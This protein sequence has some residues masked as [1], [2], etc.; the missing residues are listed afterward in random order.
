MRI[1]NTNNLG[2]FT[3]LFFAFPYLSSLLG[4]SWILAASSEE[5][6][7]VKTVGG[8][9]AECSATSPN[10]FS[11]LQPMNLKLLS[12]EKSGS[13]LTAQFEIQFV[14]C[15][16]NQWKPIKVIQNEFT[17]NIKDEINQVQSQKT[18]FSRYRIHIKDK[19]GVQR[20]VI[21]LDDLQAKVHVKIRLNSLDFTKDAIT[22][23]KYVDINLVA[24]RIKQ[25]SSD[26]FFDEVTWGPYRISF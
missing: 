12:S 5:W 13:Q 22:K 17:Q 4:S 16:K 7:N 2:I 6:T 19:D 25:T 21:A 10:Q 23:T 9:I 15:Q 24:D 14:E 11:A 20:Q 1:L 8:H 3:L 26:R 18:S